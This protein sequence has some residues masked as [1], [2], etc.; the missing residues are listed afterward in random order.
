MDLGPLPSSYVE[1]PYDF[2]SVIST[3]Y[4][5]V[6]AVERQRIAKTIVRIQESVDDLGGGPQG[7]NMIRQSQPTV[8]TNKTLGIHHIRLVFGPAPGTN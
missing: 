6:N 5:H 7:P 8:A 4:A 1:L 3:L 2:V